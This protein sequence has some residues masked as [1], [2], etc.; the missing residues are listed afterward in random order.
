MLLMIKLHPMIVFQDN[1]LVYGLN[2]NLRIELLLL[3]ISVVVVQLLEMLCRYVSEEYV[4]ET[5]GAAPG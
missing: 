5:A 4:S 2:C 3:I 1:V